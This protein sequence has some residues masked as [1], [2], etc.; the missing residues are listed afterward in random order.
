MTGELALELRDQPPLRKLLSLWPLDVESANLIAPEL[1]PVHIVGQI[2]VQIVLLGI[3]L[4]QLTLGHQ[5]L[6]LLHV[7][8]K[9]ALRV[10]I[11]LVLS[12][13]HVEILGQLVSTLQLARLG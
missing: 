3:G 1:E 7:V 6:L 5:L 9:L 13:A 10:L 8:S 4:E 12:R 2:E 11:V